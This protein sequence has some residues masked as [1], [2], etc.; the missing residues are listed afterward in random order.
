MLIVDCIKNISAVIGII[1]LDQSLER[2]THDRTTIELPGYQNDMILTIYNN[3]K[4][5]NNNIILICLMIHGGI[6][7]LGN[8]LNECD[9]ILDSWYPGAQGGYA[10]SDIIF[11]NI[12]PAGRVSVTYYENTSQLPQP[13]Q[14]DEY[15]GNGI[16][17]RYFNGNVIFPFG[18]GLSYTQFKY[19]NLR[20]NT[21]NNNININPCDVIKITVNV[22]NIGNLDGDEVVQMYK[23]YFTILTIMYQM[24][25]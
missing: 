6:L 20:I 25:V 11:G 14:M 1:G 3:I 23:I 7:S 9:V 19:S 24:F 13:G 17:Y 2:E 21:T 18:Y 4:S 12:N 22:A 5:I 8:A 16:T 15:N 10:I